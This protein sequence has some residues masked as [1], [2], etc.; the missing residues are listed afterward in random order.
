MSYYDYSAF[1]LKLDFNIFWDTISSDALFV[2]KIADS[3]SFRRRHSFSV[4]SF[5]YVWQ[6]INYFGLRLCIFLVINVIIWIESYRTVNAVLYGIKHCREYKNLD[7][8]IFLEFRY[9]RFSGLIYGFG[10]SQWPPLR[11]VYCDS[12][13]M[14]CQ[15]NARFM[16]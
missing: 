16:Q 1:P 10:N 14:G 11:S 12:S 3:A 5:T 15:S 9:L 7:R 4:P 13:W 8:G 2:K 6:R